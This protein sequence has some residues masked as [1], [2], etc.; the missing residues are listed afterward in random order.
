MSPSLDL[1]AVSRP[2]PDAAAVLLPDGTGVPY[3]HLARM[4][5][6]AQRQLDRPAKTLVVVDE[7]RTVRGVVGYLAAL[8]SGHAVMVIEHGSE[9]VWAGIVA[10]YHPELLV[11]AP[12]SRPEGMARR[13]GYCRRAAAGP[14]WLRAAGDE[15][16]TTIH[17][18]LAMLIRTSGSL[19]VPKTVRLSY[20]NLGAN[21]IAIA[22]ALR[23]RPGQR[24]LASLPLDF[25][26]GLSVL[27]SHLAAGAAT[28]LTSAAPSSAEFWWCADQMRVTCVAAVPSTF[29]FLRA[30]RWDPRDH[31]DLRRLQQSGSALD[32]ATA[33][34]FDRLMRAV[35]GDLV[36]MYGQTEATARMTYLPPERL[37][38]RLSSVGIAIPG[39]SVRICGPDGAPVP[40][41]QVGAV[42]YEGPNVMMGYARSRADLA[43]GDTEH[44][45][46]R[47]GDLGCLREGFLYLSGRAD[48]QVKVLGLRVD[49][50]QVEL[51]FASLGVAAAAV[52]G[53]GERVQ[54]VV[55]KSARDVAA[56]HCRSVTAGLGL[57]GAAIVVAGVAGI[58]RTPRGKVD[59]AAVRRTLE[60]RS[61]SAQLS[62][63]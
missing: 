61:S 14:V 49:L 15:P 35:G 19:G 56:G 63:R 25:S 51:A 17:P 16:G 27:N 4:V 24:A 29:Q 46:L 33:A 22:E 36:V 50:D 1:T 12:G 62:A 31:P 44:G 28:G 32:T 42:V 20:A 18:D 6:A 30:R 10:A 58:P 40:D 26:F 41:G 3:E 52:P 45:L 7:P 21:A 47:T 55:E 38:E 37:G 43:A 54:V 9:Q 11:L 53:S 2:A 13:W 57:P 59:Y 8:R 39:G 5:Q 48:R 60:F 23:I 34:H